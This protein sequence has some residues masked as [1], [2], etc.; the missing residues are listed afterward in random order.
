MGRHGKATQS[1]VTKVAAKRANDTR[2]PGLAHVN[3]QDNYEMSYPWGRQ[4]LAASQVQ[5]AL[6]THRHL[7][8]NVFKVTFNGNRQGGWKSIT[9]ANHQILPRGGT[10]LEPPGMTPF[11]SRKGTPGNIFKRIT[12]RFIL[13]LIIIWST[14]TSEIMQK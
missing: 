10:Q 9:L 11:K 14:S 4:H 12:W 5:L 8:H 2:Q 3:K 1:A 7:G 6:G 13:N